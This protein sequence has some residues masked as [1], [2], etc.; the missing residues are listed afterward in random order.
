[1]S[2]GSPRARIVEQ[3]AELARVLGNAHRLDLLQHVARG[4]RSVERLAQLAKLSVANTSEHLQQLRRSGYVVSR[5]EGKNVLY[6]LGDGP[7]LELL[8]ALRLLA[9]RNNAEVCVLVND[10]FGQLDR[11]EPVTRESL[12]EQLRDGSVTILDVRPEDEFA[13]GD[14]PGAIN[15]PAEDLERYIEA[16]PRD[17]EIVAYCRGTYCVL[18]FQVVGSRQ[19]TRSWSV[20]S[21]RSCRATA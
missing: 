17:Q 21:L 10:Y 11:L 3:L 5:R 4:E 15:V 2:T 20:P 14:I 1:M 18:S 19:G 9:E 8:T 12:L 7:I 6:R 16:V 13:L